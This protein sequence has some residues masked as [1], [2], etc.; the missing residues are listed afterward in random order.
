MKPKLSEIAES[1]ACQSENIQAYLNRETGKIE[2][3]NEELLTELA[4][5]DNPEDTLDMY[6]GDEKDGE[7]A[8]AIEHGQKWLALPSKLDINDYRI[9]ENFCGTQQNSD[10]RN[11]LQKAIHG[12]SAFRKFRAT[13]VQAGLLET[14]YAFKN[15]AYLEIARD[16]CEENRIEWE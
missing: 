11:M 15:D 8:H 13:V 6:G 3:L 9:M 16:W 10:L 2:M 14:W 1:M 4:D 12:R 7:L 5:T